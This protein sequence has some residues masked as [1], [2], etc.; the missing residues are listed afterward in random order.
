MTTDE[1][2]EQL[3]S[4]LLDIAPEVDTDA[5]DDHAP[6][7]RQVDLD[8]MDWLRFLRGVHQ[9]FGVDIPEADYDKLQSLADLVGYVFSRTE[10]RS[11][12]SFS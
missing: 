6:L 2:R 3:L 5:I 1:T 4:A 11:R 8:S 9:R 12:S 10:L 7:R